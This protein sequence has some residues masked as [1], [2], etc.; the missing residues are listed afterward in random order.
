MFYYYVQN[1]IQLITL[2]SGAILKEV[3]IRTVYDLMINSEF[4]E[5]GIRK[6]SHIYEEWLG[7]WS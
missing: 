2:S 3:V 1:F 5:K 7:S 6:F 4:I